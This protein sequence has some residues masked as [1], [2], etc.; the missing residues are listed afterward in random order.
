MRQ[1]S[2]RAPLAILLTLALTALGAWAIPHARAAECGDAV[3]PCQC[4]DRVVTDTKLGGTDPVLRTT[5]PCDGL[6]V[7]SR[8]TLDIGGTLRGQGDTCSGIVLEGNATGV[9]VKN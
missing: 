1:T 6:I 3:G 8:V 5:C 9:V 4:G 7:T 2:P